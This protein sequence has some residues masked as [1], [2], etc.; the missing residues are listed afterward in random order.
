MRVFTKR[1]TYT[2][3]QASPEWYGNGHFDPAKQTKILTKELRL[4]ADEQ[5]QVL[6]GLKSAKS[7][8]EAARS[9]NSLSKRD[10]KCKSASAVR[11]SDGQIPAFLDTKQRKKLDWIQLADRSEHAPVI[12]P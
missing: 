10:R 4:T 11:A 1:R 7:Q 5:S 12:F 9:D 2:C 3:A 8:L 6:D